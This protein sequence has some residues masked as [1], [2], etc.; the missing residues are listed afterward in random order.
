MS[1]QPSRP[2]R[3][4]S[5]AEKQQRRSDILSAAQ[6]LWATT[7]YADLSMSQVASSAQLA[8]GTLYLYFDTKE[9]LFLALVDRH[10]NAW[11][12]RT[13][14][15][16]AEHRP[17]TPPQLADVLVESVR[18]IS[19]LRRLLTLLGTVL[20]RRIRPELMLEFRKNVN[21]HLEHLLTLMPLERQVAQRVLRH[22]YALGIG[23]QHLAEQTASGLERGALG[24]LAEKGSALEGASDQDADSRRQEKIEQAFEKEYEL[25]VRIMIERLI[26]ETALA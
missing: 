8:K 14:A 9:E 21:A 12:G 20:E 10:L 23:W 16:L 4:R 15:L 17:Q 5:L 22:L 11:I 19:S 6:D 2:A 25:A 13:C 26:R 7:P 18:D 24:E 3:A 1:S